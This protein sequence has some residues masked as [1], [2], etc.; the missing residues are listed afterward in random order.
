MTPLA[1]VA[2]SHSPLLDHVE[3]PAG[4]GEEL[5]A[6]FDRASS[7]VREFQPDLVISFAPDH[8]N[9]FFYE[10]M[11]PACIATAAYGLGDYGSATGDLNVP[12]EAAADLAT[13]VL[14]ADV[15]IAVSHRM[16]VD[17]GAVQ[18]LETLFGGI[19]VVPVIPVFVN[20]VAPPFGPMRRIRL[21]GEA[22]GRWAA[23]R[24]E[25]ILLLASGG[26]SHDPPVPRWATASEP[27]RALLLAGRN[28][29]PEARAARQQR[30]IDTAAE[31]AAGRADIRDLNP[32]WDEAFLD[33]CA[34]GDAIAFDAYEADRMTEEAGNSS[35]E[36]RSW[37]AAVSALASAG[38]YTVRDRYYRP[39]PEYIAGFGVL[40]AH[41]N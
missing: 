41:N 25:K 38:R 3:P 4:V 30:V 29:T 31:F 15:D 11:P 19:D 10:I 40:T 37:V 2:M 14:A 6:V 16:G 23:T 32:E 36:V 35:H 34:G 5:A 17:H 1:L 9:G 27:E 22:I 8:Y 39:I 13:E 18:P 7:F 12:A 20:G 24:P 21:L 28:P 33:V 26:L